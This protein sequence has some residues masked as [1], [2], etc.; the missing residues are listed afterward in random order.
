MII[1]DNQTQTSPS[2]NKSQQLNK[3]TNYTLTQMKEK[4]EQENV[5][6]FP[7]VHSPFKRQENENDEYTV[8][9][10][11]KEG[12]EWVFNRTKSGEIKSRAVEKLHGTNTAILIEE[13]KIDTSL[14]PVKSY[15]RHGGQDMQPAKP[16]GNNYSHRRIIR[17]VQNS[18]RRGYLDNLD[19]GIHYGETVGPDFHNNMHEL[20]ENLFI[21]FQWLYDK[22]YYKSWGDYGTTF[23]DIKQWF[24]DG[25]FSLFYS[26][27]HGVDL[28]TSSV[29]NNTF[30]EGIM[31]VRKQTNPYRQKTINTREE[32]LS[33][34]IYRKVHPDL[35]KLRRD[36]FTNSNNWD[37]PTLSH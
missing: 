8:Y 13:D 17:A 18:L 10:S 27:M 21:P 4:Q 20:E 34:G 31:F 35:A 26:R 19:K 23:E 3:T 32:A 6:R 9:D 1:T 12:Y 37:G 11:I 29:T 28:Q 30:C 16:L 5:L 2:Q 24:K 25:L 36:M 22:C 7:K 33:S 14:R 15:T